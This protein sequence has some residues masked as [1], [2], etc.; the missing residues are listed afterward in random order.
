MLLP[1]ELTAVANTTHKRIY[2]KTN[3]ANM[4]IATMIS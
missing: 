1:S 3:V 4:T 2:N